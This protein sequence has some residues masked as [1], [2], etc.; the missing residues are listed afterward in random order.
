[1]A[2]LIVIKWYDQKIMELCVGYELDTIHSIC[3]SLDNNPNVRHWCIPDFYEGCIPL[4][5]EKLWEKLNQ[6]MNKWDYR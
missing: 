2:N 4:Y 6:D 5:K 1:M 3:E